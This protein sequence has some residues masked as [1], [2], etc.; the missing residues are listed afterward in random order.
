VKEMGARPVKKRETNTEKA[1]QWLD[2]KPEAREHIFK[3]LTALRSE[4]AKKV[5][6]SVK[7]FQNEDKNDLIEILIRD[8]PQE[9]APSG[10]SSTPSS[11]PE[12]LEGKLLLQV[13]KSTFM[14]KLTGKGKEYAKG[15][16]SY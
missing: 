7:S 1:M 12:S 16:L 8:C 13:L 11:Q 4:C 14:T 15:T 3:S 10:D 9:D 6:R 5:R 2:A